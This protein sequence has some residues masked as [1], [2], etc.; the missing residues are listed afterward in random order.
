[1]VC[2]NSN[3]WPCWQCRSTAIPQFVLEVTSLPRN[4]TEYQCVPQFFCS[5]PHQ[6]TNEAVQICPTSEC[7]CPHHNRCNDGVAQ[8]VEYQC[9]PSKTYEVPV[10]V[11]VRHVTLRNRSLPVPDCPLPVL[12]VIKLPLPVTDRLSQSWTN[13]SGHVRLS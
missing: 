4:K 6:K 5:C 11:M 9:L 1:M 2:N 13:L 12:P 8:S 7:N 10:P 3:A